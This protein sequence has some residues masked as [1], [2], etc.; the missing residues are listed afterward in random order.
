MTHG[1]NMFAASLTIVV[2][3]FL[4]ALPWGLPPDWRFCLP[5][6]PILATYFWMSRDDRSL[7]AFAVLAAGLLIDVT[8]GGPLGFWSLV[9][10]TLHALTPATMKIPG[11]S[12]GRAPH[13]ALTF[14]MIIGFEWALASVYYWS[15]AD[16][17]PFA[18][19]AACGLLLYFFIGGALGWGG[20]GVQ[21]SKNPSLVRGG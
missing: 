8:S 2:V 19:A 5:Q 6:L 4:A 1:F 3:S 21:R 12:P 17:K 20:R 13:F 10:V 9:Y 18:I 16:L 11:G 7:S 15:V 14:L